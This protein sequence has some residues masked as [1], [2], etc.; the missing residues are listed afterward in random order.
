MVLFGPQH[1]HD[2]LLQFT[3]QKNKTR[4]PVTLTLPMLPVLQA[5]IAATPIGASTFL[6]TEFGKPFTASRLR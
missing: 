2:G 4:K 3:Q 6:V 1:V 5:I